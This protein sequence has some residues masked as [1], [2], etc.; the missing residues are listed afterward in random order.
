MST[1]KFLLQ[2]L[3]AMR[4]PMV[5]PTSLFIFQAFNSIVFWVQYQLPPYLIGQTAVTIYQQFLG[6]QSNRAGVRMQQW[7]QSVSGKVAWVVVLRGLSSAL[8]LAVGLPAWGI[9]TWLCL[10]NCVTRQQLFVFDLVTQPPELAV[11][12]V[13]TRC[14]QWL[15]IPKLH[16]HFVSSLSGFRCPNCNAL[17][18]AFLWNIASVASDTQISV[19]LSNSQFGDRLWGCRHPNCN[20]DWRT[21]LCRTGPVV[22]DT[23]FPCTLASFSLK[24]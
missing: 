8:R 5:P 7:H 15:K 1:S 14:V 4:L 19:F 23:Q 3:A 12:V 10:H 21:S 17:R 6:D 2:L 9:N 11:P 13:Y 22:W 24:Y 18:Q 16:R 20:P